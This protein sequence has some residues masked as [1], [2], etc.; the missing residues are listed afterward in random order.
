MSVKPT[1]L[2]L[3]ALLCLSS[4]DAFSQGEQG[5][6]YSIPFN[7][8]EVPI[9]QF[10]QLAP[11]VSLR[12]DYAE[13]AI[14]NPN[15][16]L[17]IKDRCIPTEIDLVFTLYPMD[18]SRW[19]TSY[20]RLIKNRLRSL[21]ALDESL[22]DAD[23]KWRLVIQTKCADEWQARNFFH[24]FVM[25]YKV[26]RPQ[27]MAQLNSAKDFESLLT[28]KAVTHDSTVLRIMDRNRQWKN[29]LVIMDWTGSMYHYGAQVVLWHKLNLETSGIKHLI[30]FNDGD[31][32]A[33]WQKE[34]GRTGGIYYTKCHDLA[35]VV[36][37]I[38]TVMH[39]GFGGDSPENDLEAVVQGIRKVEDYDEVILIADNRSK[40]RDMSLLKN[41]KKPVRVILC[42]KAA[43]DIHP[44]YLRI[45]FKT[46]GSIHTVEHDIMAMASL[47][48]GDMIEIEGY[49]YKVRAG[50][51]ERFE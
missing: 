45:A 6:P 29:V 39:N 14:L 23:I 28:G 8:I 48:E 31:R 25:R 19:L 24:G 42:G 30:L 32:K 51:L 49:R 13:A 26:T 20:N 16:W 27:V 10:E 38:S 11:Q 37:T 12:M 4:T 1:L 40:V 47:K 5:Y 36:E 41:I 7:R 34:V 18:S 21:F 43:D 46:R 9:Y 35:E 17:R 2:L 50:E 22:K 44:D 3:F 15:D 33:T